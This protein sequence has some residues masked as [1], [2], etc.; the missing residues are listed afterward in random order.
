MKVLV[1][2]GTGFLGK[3]LALRLLLEGHQVTTVGRNEVVGKELGRL[4]I[5]FIKADLADELAI[6]ETCRGQDYVFHCAALASPWG[7]YQE[8]YNSNV[9]GTK[10]VV[11]GCQ[12]YNV[13]RMVHVSTPS[14][15][16]EW[17]DRQ[18]I[19]EN[20]VLPEKSINTYAKTKRLA[21]NIV[22]DA[23]RKG[24]PVITIRPRG[25]FGPGDHT[26]FPRLIRA[27]DSKG[28]PDFGKSVI[29]DITY[30]DNVVDAL[31]LCIAAPETSVGKK[32][33]ITNGEPIRLQTLLEE[34][35]EKFRYPL[36]FR[37]VP[38][39]LAYCA[40]AL[41]ELYAVLPWGGEP[42]ITRYGLGVLYYSQTLDITAARRELGYDPRISISEGIGQFADWWRKKF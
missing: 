32:Y 3:A 25:I 16:M 15:Y 39:S 19:K 14:I 35:F 18:Q 29:T 13:R 30:I 27:N 17:R 24:L 31:L 7:R 5:R 23:W 37:R 28:I 6:V 8:F 38:F 33:N 22:D 21:E 36:R 9:L 11:L 34:L 10:H 2:G 12:C 4:G 41:A 40:A 26:I 42:E 20:E 1:T